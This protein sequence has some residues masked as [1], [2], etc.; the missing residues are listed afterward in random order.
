M[1]IVQTPLTHE[2]QDLKQLFQLLFYFQLRLERIMDGSELSK[3][4]IEEI[5]RSIDQLMTILLDRFSAED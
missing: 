4:E 3:Y 1:K 5:T 2:Q